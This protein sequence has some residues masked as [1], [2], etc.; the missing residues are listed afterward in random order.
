MS[1]NGEPAH[2]RIK[3][4]VTF[5]LPISTVDWVAQRDNAATL[6]RSPWT[7]MAILISLIVLIGL[8]IFAIIVALQSQHESQLAL[9][10]LQRHD[11]MLAES[12]ARSQSMAAEVDALK[13][14]VR[15][16]ATAAAATTAATAAATDVATTAS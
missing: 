2:D 1:E 9:Q 7:V 5:T 12:L 3:Q 14:S 15:T 13:R 8:L 16:A 10:Q 6:L 11:G 4:R